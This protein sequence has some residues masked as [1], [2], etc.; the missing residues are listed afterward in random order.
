MV[1]IKENI[2]FNRVD[3]V[4]F[5]PCDW[6]TPW[7]GHYLIESLSAQLKHSKI[8]CVENPVD[9][10]ISLVKHPKR[11]IM[12]QNR[13]NHLRKVR[14][15]LFIYRPWIFLNTHIAAKVSIFQKLN[16]SWI[17]IQLDKVL[18]KNNFLLNSL[19]IWITDPFQEEYLSIRD[20]ILTVF[21]CYD[22][23]AEQINNSVFR[24]KHELLERE[25]RILRK[26]D[27]TFFVSESLY[28]NKRLSSNITHIIPNAVDTTHFGQA[29]K[30]STLMADDIRRIPHPIVGFLGNLSD[31]IDFTLLNWL[32][33]RNKGWSFV[34][35]GG[36]GNNMNNKQML[37]SFGKNDN[38]YLLGNKPYCQLPMYLKAFDVCLIPF[39]EDDFFSLSCSPLKLYEYLATG[40]P[41]ISTNLPGVLSF[42]SLIRIA[43]SKEEFEQHVK[44]A[45]QENPEL[46]EKRIK[47]S[48][49]HSWKKRAEEVIG[50][51]EDMANSQKIELQT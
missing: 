45:L 43:R 17:K 1:E 48:E 37:V 22:E 31:R 12:Q 51:L 18:K 7:R 25:R 30:Q 19:I 24:T 3:F 9:L 32:A 42:N 38:V 44:E 40:K 47:I 5:F 50:I 15:N 49:A 27:L 13:K 29:I 23:Y 28:E 6:E 8:L 4:I 20:G 11:W 10:V 46:H 2:T 36:K 34:L 16:F 21:D 33:V 39:R 41:I 14:D 35:V 26:V